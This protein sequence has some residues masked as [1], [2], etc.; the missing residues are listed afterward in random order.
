MILIGKIMYVLIVS[1]QQEQLILQIQE[2]EM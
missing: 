2:V 1:A